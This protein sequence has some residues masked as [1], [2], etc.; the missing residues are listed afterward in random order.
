MLLL[1]AAE[2]PLLRATHLLLLHLGV[3]LLL[4][5]L[6]LAALVLLL[7]LLLLHLLLLYHLPDPVDKLHL[8]VGDEAQVGLLL[9]AV[10]EDQNLKEK[11]QQLMKLSPLLFPSFVP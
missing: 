5:L 11:R 3:H 9:A 8:L 2:L 1:L 7:L 4:L 6:L 10:E